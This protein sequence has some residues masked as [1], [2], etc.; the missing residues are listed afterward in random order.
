M[1][2]N[3]RSHHVDGHIFPYN[4]IMW[5]NWRNRA[6]S[7]TRERE[8]NYD[9]ERSVLAQAS[10]VNSLENICY[11]PGF[12]F[13]INFYYIDN[14]RDMR[15]EHWRCSNTACHTTWYGEN[16]PTITR[17]QR[18]DYFCH[19]LRSELASNECVCMWMCVMWLC[20]CV[21]HACMP[22]M[23]FDRRRRRQNKW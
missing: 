18:A 23:R 7:E 20:A 22:E 5:T 21:Q 8:K 11:M 13:I 12:N 3:R 14:T 17:S 19:S 10:M 16:E 15:H 1:C 9:K 6:D 2:M 4:M